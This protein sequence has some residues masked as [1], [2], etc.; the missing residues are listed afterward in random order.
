MSTEEQLETNLTPFIPVILTVN[1]I[2]FIFVAYFGRKRSWFEKVI[3]FYLVLSAIIHSL[4][5]LMWALFNRRLDEPLHPFWE[6]QRLMWIEYGKCDSRWLKS[7]DCIYGLEAMAGFYCAPMAW[8]TIYAFIKN[9]PWRHVV[10]PAL[11][12][13]QA[14]GLLMTWIPEVFEGMI[15]VPVNHFVLHYGYFW[16]MQS[17]WFIFP[18]IM[19]FQSIY[20]V[21][22]M[23]P[24]AKT[25]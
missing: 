4:L 2:C 14:Y 21:S 19:V 1:A 22:R 7:D 3:L 12:V 5:E 16:A 15:H 25:E 9:K 17:P 20:E 8:I 18:V 10:Q 6:R 24:K 11:V 13:G 23:V